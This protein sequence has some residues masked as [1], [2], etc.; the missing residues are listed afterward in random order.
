[1]KKIA[2]AGLGSVG[3]RVAAALDRG[4]IPGLKL[5]AVSARSLKSSDQRLNTFSKDVIAADLSQ[6]ARSAR[7]NRGG[8]PST[9]RIHE[10]CRERAQDR[11]LNL[12]GGQCWGAAGEQS[13]NW[14]VQFMWIFTYHTI[15]CSGRA[16]CTESCKVGWA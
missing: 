11:G 13:C 5:V 15:R 8:V 12:G 6:P 10:G 3:F 4:E 9:I 7:R 16:G 2:V 1:M 14:A